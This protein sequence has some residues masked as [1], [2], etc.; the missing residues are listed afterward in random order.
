MV[1]GVSPGLAK[2]LDSLTPDER[3][4]LVEVLRDPRTFL[5]EDMNDVLAI[6]SDM[7]K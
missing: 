5:A 7:Q 3:A 1:D 4:S 2:F 6:L